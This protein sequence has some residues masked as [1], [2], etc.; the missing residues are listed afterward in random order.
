MIVGFVRYLVRSGLDPSQIMVLAYYT[1]Q[2]E[3]IKTQLRQDVYLAA[4]ESWSVRTIDGFQGEENDVILLSLVRVP[5]AACGQARPGFVADENR[6][7]VAISRAKRGLYVFGNAQTVLNGNRRSRHTWEKVVAA[8]RERTAS[9]LPVTCAAHETVA[10]MRQ[11]ED[12]RHVS[13]EGCHNKCRERHSSDILTASR[14]RSPSKAESSEDSKK[15]LTSEGRRTTLVADK[16]QT[17]D[18]LMDG[19]MRNF[20]IRCEAAAAEHLDGTSSET[21]SRLLIELGPE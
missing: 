17:S 6:A 3:L 20:F 8:F 19:G 10:K 16:Y 9:Y 18:E 21:G 13:A 4:I 7:V 1:A 5:D 15:R 11:P 14:S 12:W 2:V